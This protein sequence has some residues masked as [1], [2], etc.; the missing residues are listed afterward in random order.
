MNGKRQAILTSWIGLELN[1]LLQLNGYD[2]MEC[3]ILT[4]GL[5]LVSFSVL[6]PPSCTLLLLLMMI[7]MPEVLT[8]CEPHNAI[9]II[10]Y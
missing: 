2:G 8:L 1:I 4:Y 9:K 3:N 6:L 7:V 10:H 5:F